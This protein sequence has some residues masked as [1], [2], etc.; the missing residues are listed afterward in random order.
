MGKGNR[1]RNS[2]YQDAYA[3]SGTGAAAAK[4]QTANKDRTATFVTIAIALLLALSIVLIAFADSG[5]RE[6][7]VVVVSSENHEV[8]GTMLTYFENIA[9]TNLFSQYYNLYYSY[10]FSGDANSAYSMAYQAMSQYTL[11]DFFD[12]AVASVK[13][14]LVLCEAADKA[15]V[16]L[17]EE[18]E[19]S[20]QETLTN[21]KGQY[22]ANFGTGVKEKDIRRALELQALASKYYDT[23]VEEQL[24]S[25]TSDEIANYIEENKE[26]YYSATAI[27][28]GISLLAEDYA[29]EDAFAAAK[30]L[31]DTYVAKL[32]A[33]TDEASFKT[34]IVEYIFARDID[35]TVA[36]KIS[37]DLMP[38]E[39]TLTT[40]TNKILATLVDVL[41]TGNEEPEVMHKD[42]TLE[43]AVAA[44]YDAIESTCATALAS[45]ETTQAY[46]EESEDEETA[47]GE[48]ALWLVNADTAL[49]ATKADDTSDD[50]KYART[51][52]MLTEA[53]HLV[54]EETVNA[55][56]ILIEVA[57]NATTE[58]SDAA[59]AKAEEVLAA[60]L[61]GDKTKES[62]EALAK[63]H[64]AEPNSVFFENIAQGELV[65]EFNDWIFSEER[66][67]VGEA[68]VVKTSYGYHV[69]YWDGQG[70]NTSVYSAKEGIVSDRYTA[71]LEEGYKTLTLNEKYIAKNTTATETK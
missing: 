40:H 38:D 62:F 71:F 55:G 50:T 21:L 1:T 63:E 36:A 61:A 18:E 24:D 25:V 10:Y 26:L 49:Y 46:V 53:L 31:A 27:K 59:K 5:M 6:R 52:Y 29:D 12:S 70:E 65:A 32:E 23:Y 42:G 19:A 68:A 16:K 17:G 66:T 13:E 39:E 30:A 54:D 43:A 8:T 47:V 33:A 9:Y 7:N 45:L 64:S 69:I 48:V 3:M 15:G 41:V 60:Y 57:T 2:Q 35:A 34:A 67:Q 20:I 11:S 56:H 44:V 4:K 28:Y 22:T 51:V 37:A 58:E 14:L